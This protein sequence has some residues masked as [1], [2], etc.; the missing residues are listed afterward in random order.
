M[1]KRFTLLIVLLAAVYNVLAQDT[2]AGVVSRVDAPYFEQNVCDTRFAITSEGE[3]Y[4]VVVDGY[5]PNPYLEDLVIHYDTIPVGNEIEVV[6]TIMEIEDGNGDAFQTV[7]ISKNLNSNHQQILGFFY[8]NEFTYPGPD[9][10]SAASF[11]K[12]TGLDLYHIVING[13]LQTGIPFIINGRTL[14]EDKRYLFIGDNDVWTDY[15]GNSFNVFELVDALPYDVADLN[16]E[17]TLTTENDLCVLSPCGETRFL[18]LFDGNEYHY[19]TNK[20]KLKNNYFNDAVFMEGDSVVVGGF[21]LIRYDLFG[22]PFNTMEIVKLQSTE[23]YILRGGAGTAGIPYINIGPPVPGV[24]LAFYSGGTCFYIITPNGGFSDD[25]FLIVGNDTILVTTQQ[26]KA[27]C[28][29]SIFINNYLAPNYSVNIHQVEFEE[30]EETLQCTLAVASNP[31]YWGN[32]LIVTTIDN[33]TCFLK[34]Y[35][36]T[37]TPPDHITIGDKSVCV[38]D[39]FTASGMVSYWY[40]NNEILEKVIEITEISNVTGLAD[41]TLTDIQIN[42]TTSNDI[43]QIV[44]NHPMKAVSVCDYTGR[45]LINK[46]YDSK[47]VSLDLKD[48]KGMAIIQI[49]FKNGQTTSKKVVL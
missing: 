44:S 26:M 3:T 43:I 23:E 20:R 48:F 47:Q 7:D 39:S 17:G 1:K 32:T 14:M 2:I 46:R 40:H 30:H 49:V 41:D 8:Y 42:H 24:F 36:Y 6:G 11:V 19:L 4:Y 16:I 18:S 22:A 33:D 34:P 12:Y 45:V 9:S 37:N 29:P 10:I 27:S 35:L 28:T 31:F 38:G 25:D 15:N 13:E 21:E 5:W